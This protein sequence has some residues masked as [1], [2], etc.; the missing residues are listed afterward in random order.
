MRQGKVGTWRQEMSAGMIK[1]FELWEQKWLKDSDL[2]FK[3]D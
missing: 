2:S 3:Y 1:R